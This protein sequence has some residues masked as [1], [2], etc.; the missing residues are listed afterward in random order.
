AGWAVLQLVVS[1]IGALAVQVPA[2]ALGMTAAPGSIPAGAQLSPVDDHVTVL[3][4]DPSLGQR[5][6]AVLAAV[7]QPLVLASVLALLAR[8][9]RTV[10]R[11]ATFTAAAAA[12]LTRVGQFTASAGAAAFICQVGFDGTLSWA[13]RPPD[14]VAL[15]TLASLISLVGPA[16]WWPVIGACLGLV[17]EVVRRGVAL[18]DELE[19]VI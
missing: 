14:V 15:P 1:F 11:G 10:R 18:R 5:L 7:P 3:L 17:G 4:A 9:A 19:G 8:W 12:R 2:S 6:L 16:L 13:A